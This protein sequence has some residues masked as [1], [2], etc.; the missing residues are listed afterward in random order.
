M[1]ADGMVD[2]IV[3]T[4]VRFE[5]EYHP[6][7]V[8]PLRV[9]SAGAV[10][11]EPGWAVIAVIAVPPFVLKVMVTLAIEEDEEG[12]ALLDGVV[13]EEELEVTELELELEVTDDAVDEEGVALLD[14]V[15]EEEELE[16]TEL[17]LELEL[18]VTDD[19]EE[20]DDVST[21]VEDVVTGFDVGGRLELEEELETVMNPNAPIAITRTNPRTNH[22]Q[23]GILLFLS[24]SSSSSSL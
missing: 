20:L 2:G 9:G 21:E 8:Y 16:V 18:E 23:K 5:S 10:I 24:L 13:E 11:A 3:A 6:A 17:E 1:L 4:W 7:K 15:V 14:G 22:N 19:V 12:V